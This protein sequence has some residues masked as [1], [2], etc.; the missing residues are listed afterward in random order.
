MAAA[1]AADLCQQMPAALLRLPCGHV[2]ADQV[3]ITAPRRGAHRGGGGNGP[4][5]EEVGHG[6]EVDA[7]LGQRPLFRAL[8]QFGQLLLYLTA[9]LAAQDATVGLAVGRG[10]RRASAS[11]S[12]MGA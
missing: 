10:R 8:P 1:I 5:R 4:A 7:F 9:P 11:A 12:P 6:Q 2:Q 3:R